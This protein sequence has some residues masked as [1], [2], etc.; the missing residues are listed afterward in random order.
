[1]KKQKIL[2]NDQLGSNFNRDYF[3]KVSDYN[4]LTTVPLWAKKGKLLSKH[5]NGSYEFV[6]GANNQ[7][8]LRILDP[9]N[10]W[11]LTKYLVVLVNV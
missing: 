1:L 2:V 5:P 4:K 7:V 6:K 11:S 8:E 3:I 9:R 10:F